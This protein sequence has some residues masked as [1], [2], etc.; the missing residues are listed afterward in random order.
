MA[1]E[2]LPGIDGTVSVPIEQIIM[3]W[4]AGF[5]GAEILYLNRAV[6]RSH[7]R[8]LSESHGHWPPIELVHF[9]NN[10]IITGNYQPLNAYGLV[11]GRH[12]LE[13][14]KKLKY[15]YMRANIGIYS[16]LEEVV[17]SAILANSMHGIDSSPKLRSAHALWMWQNHGDT[18]SIEDIAQ[19]AGIIPRTLRD[20][21]RREEARDDDATYVEKEQEE[22]PP[23]VS[24]TFDLDNALTK[25]RK[26]SEQLGLF[27][28]PSDVMKVSRLLHE[29]L[30]ELP[31]VD[32]GNAKAFIR[33]V[34][35]ILHGVSS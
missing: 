11:D 2:I 24:F 13:A 28:E 17:H 32:R 14:G 8:R 23:F 1:I 26:K 12:R 10:E 25:L 16:S 22:Q 33:T 31:I 30:R 6:D 18:M 3:L 21:I 5:P 35:E 34:V 27:Y 29:I 15:E 4:D 9:R 19:I 7:V 20:A